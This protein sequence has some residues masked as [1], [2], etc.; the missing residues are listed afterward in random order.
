MQDT[1]IEKKSSSRRPNSSITNSVF[2]EQFFGP[3]IAALAAFYNVPYYV[4]IFFIKRMQRH[5]Q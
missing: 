4:G 1:R 3:K 2:A 5:R